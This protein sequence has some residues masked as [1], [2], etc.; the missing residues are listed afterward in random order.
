MVN[1]LLAQLQP[2][3][4]VL[5]VVNVLLRDV[6]VQLVIVNVLIVHRMIVMLVVV[7]PVHVLVVHVPVLSFWLLEIDKSSSLWTQEAAGADQK[8][9]SVVQSSEYFCYVL[10]TGSKSNLYCIFHFLI[11]Y[12]NS[13]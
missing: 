10:V 7:P 9:L 2:V 3:A 8:F 6:S 5:T 4:L 12:Y 1:T 13:V 11:S